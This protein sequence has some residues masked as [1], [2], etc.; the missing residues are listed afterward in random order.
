MRDLPTFNLVC[1]KSNLLK[2]RSQIS[3]NSTSNWWISMEC[4]WLWHPRGTRSSGGT[5]LPKLSALTSSNSTTFTTRATSRI[6]TLRSWLSKVIIGRT[7]SRFKKLKT[8]RWLIFSSLHWARVTS[9]SRFRQ[10]KMS[11]NRKKWWKKSWMRK[12]WMRQPS[13]AHSWH[14]SSSSHSRYP[15]RCPSLI[16]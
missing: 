2:T 12:N 7:W 11:T 10:R 5:I 15:S 14:Q 13:S 9:S 8:K 1:S 6:F 4:W 16:R 3:H